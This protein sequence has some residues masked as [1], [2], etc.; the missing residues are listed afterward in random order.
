ML[1]RLAS[2]KKPNVRT[3]YHN[4]VGWS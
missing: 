2:G 4:F 3:N 1:E